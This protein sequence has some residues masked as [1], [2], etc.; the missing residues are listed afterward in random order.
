M[1]HRAGHE[2]LTDIPMEPRATDPA[3]LRGLG[4]PEEEWADGSPGRD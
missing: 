3:Q 2:I 4:H 1:K